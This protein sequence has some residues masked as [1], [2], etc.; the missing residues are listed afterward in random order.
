MS[1]ARAA[2]IDWAKVD[3]ITDADV[4]RHAREDRTA[5]PSDRAWRKM[6]QDGRISFVPPAEVDVRGIREKLHLSQLAFAARFG[7]TAGAVRQ[8]EHGR[9]RPHGPARVLLTIIDREPD[10]VRRALEAT[11]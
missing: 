3:A 1:E 7:F 4:A 8:W 11:E 9:R 6:A 2:K 5:T 10:A